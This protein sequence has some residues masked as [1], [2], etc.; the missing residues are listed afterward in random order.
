MR[1]TWLQRLRR[2][3]RPSRYVTD[4]RGI[5]G[6]PQTRSVQ[7]HAALPSTGQF[8]TAPAANSPTSLL[9]MGTNIGNISWMSTKCS[10]TIS[11][12]FCNII[13]NKNYAFNFFVA[14]LELLLFI[15]FIQLFFIFLF[16]M[17]ISKCKNCLAVMI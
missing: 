16:N 3:R 15:L 2:D 17:S 6:R 11:T 5:I 1:R 7:L 4:A 12:Q 14:L 10:T 9:F 13:L 8:T